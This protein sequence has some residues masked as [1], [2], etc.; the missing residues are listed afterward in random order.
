V[1]AYLIRRLGTSIVVL[2]GVSILI[3][4]LLHIVFPSPAI[5]VLGV[6][7]NRASIAA[8]NRTHGFDSP[9]IVQY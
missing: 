3:F 2:F 9:W 7:A 5:V 1:T 8:F 6:K 4:L